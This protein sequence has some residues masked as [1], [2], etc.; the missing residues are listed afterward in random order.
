VPITPTDM[1]TAH[2]TLTVLPFYKPFVQHGGCAP[3]RRA[4][5]VKPSPG[6]TDLPKPW[7]ALASSLSILWSIPSFPSSDMQALGPLL[8][9]STPVPGPPTSFPCHRAII[10]EM[11][12]PRTGLPPS[13]CPPLPLIADT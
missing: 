12:F 4:S 3:L 6:G 7:V 11:P 13:L 5:P 1:T 9:T 2:N 8:P 10:P